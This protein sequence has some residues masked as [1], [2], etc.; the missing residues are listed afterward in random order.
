MTIDSELDTN[1]YWSHLRYLHSEVVPAPSLLQ[2]SQATLLTLEQ[3]AAAGC[4]GGDTE[5]PSLTRADTEYI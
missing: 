4:A 1:L 3:G 5:P 2:Q